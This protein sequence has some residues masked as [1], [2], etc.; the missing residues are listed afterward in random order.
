MQYQS[1]ATKHHEEEIYQMSKKFFV[2]IHIHYVSRISFYSWFSFC[3]VTQEQ[4]T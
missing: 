4:S 2:C 1:S 3:S